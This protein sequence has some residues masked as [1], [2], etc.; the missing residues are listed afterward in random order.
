MAHTDS[1]GKVKTMRRR[2]PPALADRP[3]A[4]DRIQPGTLM[5]RQ[6]WRLIKIRSL[7]EDRSTGEIIDDAVRQ[8]MERVG[9]L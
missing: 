9:R 7:E 8:Y 2:K 1:R 6:L 3:E 5:D 4:P